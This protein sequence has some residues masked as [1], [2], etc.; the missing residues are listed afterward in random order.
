MHWRLFFFLLRKAFME[1]IAYIIYYCL[2]SQWK[3]HFLS[4]QIPHQSI[5][6]HIYGAIL[7]SLVIKC[8]STSCEPAYRAFCELTR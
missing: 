7:L 4:N 2:D 5:I 8:L 1:T 3:I 6:I